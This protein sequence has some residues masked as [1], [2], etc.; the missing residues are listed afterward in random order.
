MRV[1][2]DEVDAFLFIDDTKLAKARVVALKLME[3]EMTLAQVFNGFKQESTQF[4]YKPSLAY[5][6]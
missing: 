5:K 6:L 4:W 2:V 3:I 1:S